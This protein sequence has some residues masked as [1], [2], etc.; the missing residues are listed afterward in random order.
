MVFPKPNVQRGDSD[1]LREIRF[2]ERSVELWPIEMRRGAFDS[3]KFKKEDSI[4]L[5]FFN[6]LL[7][8][9]YLP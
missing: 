7:D 8:I 9:R 1:F 6:Y 5:G 4:F 3:T 2:H